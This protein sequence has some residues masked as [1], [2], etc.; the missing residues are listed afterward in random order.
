MP[1]VATHVVTEVQYGVNVILTFE[2]KLSSSN[3]KTHVSG[4]LEAKLQRDL[5]SIEGSASADI[6]GT[7]KSDL[8]ALSVTYNGDFHFDKSPIT[9]SEGLEVVRKLPTL[10]TKGSKPMKVYLFPLHLL[11]SRASKLPREISDHMV[12][13]AGKYY[14]ALSTVINKANR[15]MDNQ[16][17]QNLSNRKGLLQRFVT[18]AKK[19]RSKLIQMFVDKLPQVRATGQGESELLEALIAMKEYMPVS[20]RQMQSWLDDR[21]DEA[22]QL[23]A[24]IT[25][26]NENSNAVICFKTTER[27]KRL[28]SRPEVPKLVVSV[29]TAM[30]SPFLAAMEGTS[31]SDDNQLEGDPS[32]VDIEEL[33]NSFYSLSLFSEA[34]KKDVTVDILITEA[35]ILKIGILAKV[36]TIMHLVASERRQFSIPSA[37]TDVIIK[38]TLDDGV[39][40]SWNPPKHGE[41]EA[42]GYIVSVYGDNK[43]GDVELKTIKVGPNTRHA[44]F[45]GLNRGVKLYGSVQAETVAGKSPLARSENSIKTE[46]IFIVAWIDLKCVLRS[47]EVVAMATRS[48]H[49]ADLLYHSIHKDHLVQCIYSTGE[50]K[51]IQSYGTNHTALREIER[52]VI[53]RGRHGERI[54]NWL[55]VGTSVA[56]CT[57]NESFEEW[58]SQSY[59]KFKKRLTKQKK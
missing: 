59:G 51:F 22:I 36:S 25:A 9:F 21:E 40:V 46:G 53:A 28:T 34:N 48:L 45:E 12:S 58:I 24:R 38:S 43:C 3:C 42:T 44:R 29:P 31:Q 50:G 5:A 8:N 14:D 41:G 30:E 1:Q 57:K 32:L 49:D 39:K 55:T 15:M 23:I 4:D 47:N 17:L 10:V 6:T 56:P 54:W 33:Q 27:E 7:D 13:K 19:Q 11:D 52:A 37:P 35:P 2:Q 20:L 18:A 26:V 16:I